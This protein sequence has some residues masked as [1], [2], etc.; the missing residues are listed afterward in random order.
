V[1]PAVF[2]PQNRDLVLFDPNKPDYKALHTVCM[3]EVMFAVTEN[4]NNNENAHAQVLSK[5]PSM[6][7]VTN[8]AKDPGAV[9]SQLDAYAAHAVIEW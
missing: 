4:N 2:H 8:A 1:L 3:C 9:K 7:E 6:L 5:V